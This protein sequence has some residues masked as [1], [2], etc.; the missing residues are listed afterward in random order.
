LSPGIIFTPAFTLTPGVNTFYC[1]EEWRG[2]QRISATALFDKIY[3]RGTTL[4]LGAKLNNEWA[5]VAFR[6]YKL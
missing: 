5:A 3:D 6:S 4:P 1:L 2:E